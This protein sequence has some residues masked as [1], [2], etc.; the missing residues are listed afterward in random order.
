MTYSP[1]V[2]NSSIGDYFCFLNATSYIFALEVS[3][4]TGVNIDYILGIF[5]G[6]VNPPFLE[7]LDCIDIELMSYYLHKQNIETTLIPQLEALVQ[8]SPSK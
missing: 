6:T 7:P 4:M 1:Y 8:V 3:R 5:T 2:G